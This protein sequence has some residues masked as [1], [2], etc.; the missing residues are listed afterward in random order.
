MD[1]FLCMDAFVRV[2]EVGNFSEVARQ[3]NV[4]KSVVTSR[5]QQLEEFVGVPLF[6][7]TT[8]NVSLSES[9][10]AYF[11]EC[12]QLLAKANQIV[13]QMRNCRHSPSGLLR[14]H[15]IP[16]FVLNHFSAFLGRFTERYPAINLDLVVND[17][18]IDPVREGFDCALQLFS[19]ISEELVQRKLFPIHRL[20]CAS[21]TYIRRHPAITRP[22][23]LTHHNLG[24]Y[25]RYP[26][27]DKWLFS[28]EHETI[29]LALTPKI[30]TNSVHFLRDIARDG[31]AIVCLPTIVAAQDIIRGDLVPL[32]A[33]YQLP[34]YWM[35]AVYPHT[36]RNAVK[37]KLFLDQLFQEFHSPPWDEALARHGAHAIAMN[38]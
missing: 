34:K 13:D 11:D 3:L 37:L 28:N 6:H 24:L 25:S 18:V 4:S 8:R 7:R 12:S 23:D 26:T 36:Q 29:E 10:M 14:V 21:P 30:K 38:P 17:L 2:A 9:G 27:R 19:P 22:E 16:G 32:V 1:Y 20:F 33:N 31:Q 15:A 5:I 35:S